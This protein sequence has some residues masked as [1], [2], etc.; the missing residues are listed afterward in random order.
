MRALS[1]R[2]VFRFASMAEFISALKKPDAG[3]GADSAQTKILNSRPTGD[4]SIFGGAERYRLRP[5]APAPVKMPPD[6]TV[7][8]PLNSDSQWLESIRVQFDQTHP[9]IRQFKSHSSAEESKNNRE[10]LL[11]LVVLF[12]C[13]ILVFLILFGIFYKQADG[14]WLPLARNG[15][16]AVRA[17]QAKIG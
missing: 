9:E 15:I 12:F 1:P 16:H 8:L 13:A 2:I 10:D 4:L 17:A 5:S 7:N 3:G 11:F 6:Q 14:R